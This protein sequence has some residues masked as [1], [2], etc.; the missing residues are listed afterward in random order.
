MNF[1]EFFNVP[2]AEVEGNKKSVVMTTSVR[3]VIE[4]YF[5]THQHLDRPIDGR[6]TLL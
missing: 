1:T 5:S 4:E 2:L 6:L 3:D